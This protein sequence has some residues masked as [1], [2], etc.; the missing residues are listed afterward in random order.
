MPKEIIKIV[1]VP[2][3]CKNFEIYKTDSKTGKRTIFVI[4]KKNLNYEKQKTVFLI[5][6][7]DYEKEF[8][9]LL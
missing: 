3:K 7:P 5:E 6:N 4:S 2:S 1:N 9:R 8:G